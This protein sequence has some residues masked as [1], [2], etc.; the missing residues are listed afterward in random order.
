MPKI[1]LVDTQELKDI[2]FCLKMVY[3][4]ENLALVILER[5]ICFFHFKLNK[6]F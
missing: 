1:H 2:Y 5:Q 6:H 3:Y 4:S